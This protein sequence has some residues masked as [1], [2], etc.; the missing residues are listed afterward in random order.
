MRGTNGVHKEQTNRDVQA[1]GEQANRV[2]A[3]RVQVTDS[4]AG[5]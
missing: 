5:N 4:S 3:N 2:Q 1:N